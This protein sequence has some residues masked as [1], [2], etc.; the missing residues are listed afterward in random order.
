MFIV[1]D[2]VYNWPFSRNVR[3]RA[4]NCEATWR[5]RNS[6]LALCS[7]CTNLGTITGPCSDQQDRTSDAD[8]I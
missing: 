1:R 8:M 3:S 7:S 4:H 2:G 6:K 5:P